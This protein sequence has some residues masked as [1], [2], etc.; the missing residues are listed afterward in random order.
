MGG[1]LSGLH[2]G[3]EGQPPQDTYEWAGAEAG[4]SAESAG[5]GASAESAGAGAAKSAESAGV[6]SAANLWQN[7]SLANVDVDA[8]G[9]AYKRARSPQPGEG[10]RPGAN[11]T[12]R[13]HRG[14]LLRCY[15]HILELEYA[16]W[17]IASRNNED[18]PPYFD[19]HTVSSQTI[20]V[21]AYHRNHD[22]D[23]KN[24]NK[25]GRPHRRAVLSHRRTGFPPRASRAGDG[26][27]SQA[28]FPTTLHGDVAEAGGATTT[29]GDARPS[30]KRP[31]DADCRRAEGQIGCGC[32][33]VG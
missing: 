13:K 10:R 26:H 6:D 2:G 8:V 22:K 32:G 1:A 20:S 17:T 29:A 23:H 9:T 7:F 14:K 3:G 33:R 16:E 25:T 21:E 28:A 5:A 27:S 12:W 19:V 4:R 11:Q 31:R 30:T 15:A 18:V 24:Q